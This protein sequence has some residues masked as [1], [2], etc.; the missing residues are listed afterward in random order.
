MPPMKMDH[1][2]DPKKKLSEEIGE[3][4]N[5]E[6]FNNQLLV[7][8]Y[9]RPKKTKSGIILTEKTVEEDIYQSKVG[10]VVKKGPAAFIDPRGEWFN[11]VDI[12]VGDWV[13]F[14]PS[15]GWSINV[16][17]V[18]CRI[19]DDMNIRGRINDPDNVW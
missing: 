19:I 9:I 12:Q 6:I 7:A 2:V 3:L 1:E 17:N 11:G 16:N 4:A 8:L 10:L 18:P 5:V 15:D 13:V 14:R